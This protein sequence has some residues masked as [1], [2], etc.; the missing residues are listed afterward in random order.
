MIYFSHWNIETKSTKSSQKSRNVLKYHGQYVKRSRTPASGRRSLENFQSGVKLSETL[1][2]REEICRKKKDGFD[3][4]YGKIWWC[5]GFTRLGNKENKLR[6]DDSGSISFQSPPKTFFS[7][8]SLCLFYSATKIKH[9]THSPRYISQW[10]SFPDNGTFENE[11]REKTSFEHWRRWKSICLNF[12][13]PI[14]VLCVSTESEPISWV[15][16]YDSWQDNRLPSTRKRRNSGAG[17]SSTRAAE[18]Q[19]TRAEPLTPKSPPN[20]PAGCRGQIWAQESRFKGRK[21]IFAKRLVSLLKRG[22]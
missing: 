6:V 9:I 16:G 14:P 2:S 18:H 4:S 22:L 8:A 19:S 5:F 1:A 11:N 13:S 3:K 10:S 12:H 7:L 15:L 17:L 21:N 20:S